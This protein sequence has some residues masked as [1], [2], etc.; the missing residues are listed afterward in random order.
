MS[1]IFISYR[2]TDVPF[3]AALLDNAL[4][5]RFGQER[6]FRDSRSLRPGALFDPEIMQAVRDATA[7]LVVIGPGWAGSTDTAGMRQIDKADDFIHR[8]VAEALR[9][10]VR[11]I[12]VLVDVTRL[13]KPALPAELGALAE[14]Q[15]Q[16]V[17]M[18]ESEA[19]VRALLDALAATLP[20]F[21]DQE[22]AQRGP[23]ITADRIGA[24]FNERVRVEGDLNIK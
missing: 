4:V 9:H 10:G 18:R 7:M 17:R 22:P 13:A 14:R 11:V 15:D 2:S 23:T 5:A 21:A 1:H 12:P 6:V 19:D 3:A 24:V 16:T 8:E 20:G